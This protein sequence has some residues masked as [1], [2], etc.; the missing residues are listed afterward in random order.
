MCSRVLMARGKANAMFVVTKQSGRVGG[1]GK[2]DTN[3]RELVPSPVSLVL[4]P[5]LYFSIRDVL[6]SQWVYDTT[7]LSLEVVSLG[8]GIEKSQRL[9]ILLAD[10]YIQILGYGTSTESVEYNKQ[11]RELSFIS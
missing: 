10:S 9:T 1:Y 6:G 8:A 4:F 2:S 11:L 3:A 5:Q 7:L